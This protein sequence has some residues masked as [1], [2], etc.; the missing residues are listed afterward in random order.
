[1]KKLQKFQYLIKLLNWILLMTIIIN[2]NNNKNIIKIFSFLNWIIIIKF[3]IN[4]PKAIFLPINK[5]I[6]NLMIRL[7][8]FNNKIMHFQ[9]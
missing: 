6:N 5:I 9:K 1:M 2:L 7:K 8:L 3:L 4:Y